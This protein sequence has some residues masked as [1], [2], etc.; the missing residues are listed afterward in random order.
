MEIK[1]NIQKA[2]LRS[3]KRMLWP[4]LLLILGI[5]VVLIVG[6]FGYNYRQKNSLPYARNGQAINIKYYDLVQHSVKG[7]AKNNGM[8]FS[9][10]KEFLNTDHSKTASPIQIQLSRQAKLS[11]KTVTATYILAKA[12]YI[13]PPPSADAIKT[14]SQSITSPS[15][16]NVRNVFS[17]QLFGVPQNLFQGYKVVSSAG[18][19]FTS[20]YIKKDAWARD[21][22]ASATDPNAKLPDMHGRII[23]AFG[24]SAIYY[25]V[26]YTTKYDWQTNQAVW[27]QVINSIKIDQ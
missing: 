23:T 13:N 5:V 18:A 15:Q 3:S 16:N 19:N 21:F 4:R 12:L 27:N 14:I 25:F 7:L 2:P 6:Y 22:S 8:T 9:A 24:K 1:D 20:N 10:P 26:I 17:P 11:N